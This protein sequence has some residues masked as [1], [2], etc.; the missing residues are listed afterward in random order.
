MK[1]REIVKREEEL[2]EN[3]DEV[4]TLEDF[5][6]IEEVKEEENMV[7]KEDPDEIMRRL[8]FCICFLGAKVLSK[9]FPK[10]CGQAPRVKSEFNRDCYNVMNCVRLL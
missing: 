7:M 2:S 1:K 3:E 4:L 5:H 6:S 8:D 9:D 10:L